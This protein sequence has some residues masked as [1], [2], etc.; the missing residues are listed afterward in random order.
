ML[1][2]IHQAVQKWRY[3]FKGLKLVTKASFSECRR[4]VAASKIS[5]ASIM[6]RWKFLRISCGWIVSPLLIFLIGVGDFAH[7]KEDVHY[8]SIKE[9]ESI[10]ERQACPSNVRL[11]PRDQEV[12]DACKYITDA[13][14]PDGK[15]FVHCGNPCFNK[16]QTCKKNA[17]GLIKKYK[18]FLE[19]KCSAKKRG[20][21][22][23]SAPVVS[24]P[25]VTAPAVSAPAIN[26]KTVPMCSNNS[27]DCIAECNR[28]AQISIVLCRKECTELTGNQYCFKKLP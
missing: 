5:T 12:D 23:G 20:S 26:D 27:D 25:A 2:R 14:T 4:R 21:D 11:M 8:P 18:A 6:K 19:E 16:W 3:Q 10:L 22:K 24:V 13:R 9:I 1:S 15:D 7:S 17:E 28:E